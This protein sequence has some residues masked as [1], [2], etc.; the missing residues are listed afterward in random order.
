MTAICTSG[1]GDDTYGVIAG[2]GDRHTSQLYGALDLY[3]RA[4][5]ASTHE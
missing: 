4:A 1:V 3:A 2:C 5:L